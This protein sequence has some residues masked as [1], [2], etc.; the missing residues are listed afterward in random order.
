M[1]PHCSTLAWKIPW[2]EGPGRLQSMGSLRVGHDWSD[3]AAAAAAEVPRLEQCHEQ[4][5]VSGWK[6]TSLFTPSSPHPAPKSP[7]DRT[8]RC[9]HLPYISLLY[10]SLLH[11][12]QA[13][14]VKSFYAHV[15]LRIPF[16]RVFISFLL[17]HKKGMNIIYVLQGSLQS[18][19][20]YCVP[21]FFAPHWRSLYP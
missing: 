21:M 7:N 16:F 14:G 5:P 19:S 1:P 6:M 13:L 8:D 9:Y 10:S 17:G 20:C 11:F 4:P 3:L 18:C 12:C 2:T 15:Q